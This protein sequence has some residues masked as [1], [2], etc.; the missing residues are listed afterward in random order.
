LQY[1][2]EDGGS[3]DDT[4]ECIERVLRDYEGSDYENVNAEVV[5]EPD[6]G[7]YD[8]LGKG[9]SHARGDVIAYLNAG[10]YYSPHCFDVVLDVMENHDVTW[11]TGMRVLYNQP[12]QVIDVRVPG[13]F[14]RSLMQSGFYG[15]RGKLGFLQQ[16]ST[17]WTAELMRSLDL[18]RLR[19]FRLAGDYFIWSS[20]AK[21][22]ELFVV[23]TH[24]GGFRFHGGHLSADMA[25]YRRE[26]RPLLDRMPYFAWPLATWDL[27]TQQLP[28]KLRP[29]VNGARLLTWDAGVDQFRSASR[30]EA[31]S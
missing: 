5:S 15:Y 23:A 19:T 11:L 9:L 28:L 2:I 25:S 22:A 29:Y 20:F 7:M 24:L 27:L 6:A 21:A 4:L 3:T 16:E 1:R 31:R 17:F 14:R 18:D 8:A 12:G 26:M 30:L 10:D 13:P